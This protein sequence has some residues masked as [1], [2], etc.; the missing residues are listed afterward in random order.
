M[1]N[2]IDISTAINDN[3]PCTDNHYR[4]DK[5]ARYTDSELLAAFTQNKGSKTFVAT[6]I[7]FDTKRSDSDIAAWD[8]KRL[9]ANTRAEALELAR[10]YGVRIL[11]KRATFLHYSI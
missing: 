1:L 11:G 7:P 8:E 4:G 3:S 5:M 2:S 6:F 9:T 10:E